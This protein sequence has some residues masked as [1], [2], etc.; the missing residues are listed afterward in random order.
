MDM[1]WRLVGFTVLTFWWLPLGFV[2]SLLAVKDSTTAKLLIGVCAAI[3][4]LVQVSPTR[5]LLR[6]YHGVKVLE[7]LLVMLPIVA[8][9]LSYRHTNIPETLS[10]TVWLQLAIA[11]GVLAFPSCIGALIL[12][13]PLV[14]AKTD[15]QRLAVISAGVIGYLATAYCTVVTRIQI[16]AQ[17]PH[18][19]GIDAVASAMWFAP[20]AAISLGLATA[21]VAARGESTILAVLSSRG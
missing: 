6:R 7:C 16:E 3:V 19:D 10:S 1:V 17:G 21:A 4:V 15:S 8:A 18:I 2:F 11:G 14:G 13:T 20:T 5:N 9:A 12:A